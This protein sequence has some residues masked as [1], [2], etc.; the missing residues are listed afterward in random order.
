[1]A[2]RLKAKTGRRAK[3]DMPDR[4]TA[5]EWVDL[6]RR[7]QSASD[8][9]VCL[10]L[11]AEREEQVWVDGNDPEHLLRLLENFAAHG[12]FEPVGKLIDSIRLLPL[13]QDYLEA[14]RSGKT[15]QKAVEKLGDVYHLSPRT[16]ERY[17]RVTDKP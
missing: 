1:M 9:Q 8:G 5:R 11:D 12:T 3:V 4:E 2:G 13:R 7:A 14:R 17:V 15:H 10:N 16:I 6:Y